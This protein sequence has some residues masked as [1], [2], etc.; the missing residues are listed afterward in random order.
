MNRLTNHANPT[1]SP[2]GRDLFSSLKGESWS[3]S[4]GSTSVIVVVEI[5]NDV[6]KLND[7]YQTREYADLF[8]PMY[9]ALISPYDVSDELKRLSRVVYS[10][11]SLPA[12]KKLTLARYDS[13]E[14][15]C[16]W[17]PENLF[18]QAR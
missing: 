9:A 16:E 15:F 6:L 13:N 5:K 11:L 3:G 10:L 14:A 17:F 12:Y 4:E 18:E 1:L 7:V 2:K 8:D